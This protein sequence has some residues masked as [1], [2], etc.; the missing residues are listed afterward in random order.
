MAKWV[1]IV[2]IYFVGAFVTKIVITI[3]DHYATLHNRID[4]FD[5]VGMALWFIFLPLWARILAGISVVMW[6]IILLLAFL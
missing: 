5:V 4:D 1:L 2:I 3:H 6:I